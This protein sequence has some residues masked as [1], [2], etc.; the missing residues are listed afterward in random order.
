M[1]ILRPKF[2]FPCVFISICSILFFSAK[3]EVIKK[4]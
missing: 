3:S 1:E 4:S 2:L